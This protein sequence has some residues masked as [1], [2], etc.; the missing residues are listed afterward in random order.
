MS[1]PS[2]SGAETK[3][4]SKNKQKKLDRYHNEVEWKKSRRKMEQE[5]QREKFK[6]YRQQG[7]LSKEELKQCQRSRLR[8]AL[9]DG[10]KVCIDFQFE[11]HMI[12][13]ELNHF[14]NQAK[15]VYSSNKSSEN[16]FN[17]HFIN[18]KKTSETYRMCCNKNDGF[19][20]YLLHFEEEGIEEL[21]DLETV[22]YL[23][24]DS[25]TALRTLDPEIVYIIGGLVDDSVRKDTSSRYSKSVGIKTARLPI[26]EHMKKA[27]TGSFKQ[28]LTV[29]QVFDILLSFHETNDWRTALEKHI[30]SR[31][32]FILK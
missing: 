6:Q 21:F 23:S 14:V 28:I 29:N 5:K 22:V 31:T 16:P 25:E 4:L 24:P 19:E 13:K 9:E 17:L 2:Q 32:G 10:V 12:Q 18:L 8:S 11:D 27:E 15:R 26:A 7:G 30:P 1:C 3:F 20:K